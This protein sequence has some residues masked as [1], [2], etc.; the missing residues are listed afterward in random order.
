MARL[1]GADTAQTSS[2][3][4]TQAAGRP[5]QEA[6]TTPAG[7]QQGA[8]GS[9]DSNR[10]LMFYTLLSQLTQ[11]QGVVYVKFPSGQQQQWQ[12]IRMEEASN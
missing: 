1:E 5:C 12:V 3:P 7:P 11:P 2:I 9:I 4:A 6:T 10:Q 8:R